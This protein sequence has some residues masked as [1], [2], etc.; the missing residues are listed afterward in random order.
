MMAAPFHHPP[1]RASTPPNSK[2][3]DSAGQILRPG[4]D[5]PTAFTH[6]R[7][8]SISTRTYSLSISCSL[9][10]F[11]TLPDGLKPASTAGLVRGFNPVDEFQEIASNPLELDR[12]L[13]L[14]GI[15]SPLVVPKKNCNLERGM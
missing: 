6:P 14:A 4:R 10:V 2:R 12:R 11:E 9:Y 3:F 8:Y 5:R 13:Y 7:T 15:S 1:P